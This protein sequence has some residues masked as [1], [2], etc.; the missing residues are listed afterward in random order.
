[1]LTR[2][3]YESRQSSYHH[4]IAICCA[5][6]KSERILKSSMCQSDVIIHKGHKTV[7]AEPVTQP[8]SATGVMQ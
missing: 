3:T 6:G 8:H 4:E 7:L 2:I 5:V 1:M